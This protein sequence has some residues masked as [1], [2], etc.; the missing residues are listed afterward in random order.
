MM[1]DGISVVEFRRE[2]R[3]LEDA[4][5]EMIKVQGSRVQVQELKRTR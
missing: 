4:F 1:L 5:V 2:E 3:R